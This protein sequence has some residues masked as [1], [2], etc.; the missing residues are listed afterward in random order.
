VRALA[1]YIQR[2]QELGVRGTLR[3]IGQ[4]GR[5]AG[6]RRTRALWWGLRAHH[7]LSDRA[8]L[9]HLDGHWPTVDAFLAHLAERPAT[10][11]VL[12]HD[13]PV[14]TGRALLRAFPDYSAALFAEADAI[15]RG[16][17]AVMGRRVTVGADPDWHRDP[18][19][20]ARFPIRH[21]GYLDQPLWSGALPDPHPLWSLNRH[22]SLV[23]LALAAWLS[24]EERFIA[25]LTRNLAAWIRDNPVQMGINWFSA[26]E[27]ALRLIAWCVV[28]QCVRG[29]AIFQ[30][31]VGRALVRSMLEH[32]TFVR[33]HLS[34]R[35]AV[36]G[37]HLLGEAAGLAVAGA[38]LPEFRA[39]ADWRVTGM[40]ILR[41][42]A[43]AQTHPDG[44]NRE[45]ATGYHRFV[46]DVLL[47][48]VALGRRGLLPAV[49]DLEAILERM[50]DALPHLM[51]PS[52]EA[53]MWGDC[54]YLLALPLNERRAYGDFSPLLS[55]GAA[56]FRKPALKWAARHFAIE[57]FWLLGAEGLDVWDRLV[58]EPPP[59]AARA[60]ES[61][62][63]Y[64]I[65]DTWRRHSD[66]LMMRCGPFGWGGE[67]FCA[68]AHCDLL[69][70]QVWLA[71]RPLL[72]DPGTHTYHGPWRDVFRLTAAHNTLMVDGR[73]QAT[74][75][76][77]FG[78]QHIPHARCLG[79][80]AQHVTAYARPAPG[81]THIRAVAH[82]GAG[83][84]SVVDSV[85]GAGT[86]EVSWHFHLDP[87][88]AVRR[89]DGDESLVVDGPDGPFARIQPPAGVAVEVADGWHAP[90][91]GVKVPAPV[92][93]ARWRGPLTREGLKF[94]W[95]F[96]H[97]DTAQGEQP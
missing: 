55:A 5:E 41:Q 42:Q 97:V 12:P 35:E 39:A 34:D 40:R 51:A 53:V 1:H 8:L 70:L 56:L 23:T 19:S 82:P 88:L 38:I 54:G 69:S 67:G 73:E 80:S 71:G 58:A 14:Q 79:W 16:E 90:A 3:R 86:H 68:H 45:Q 20:E 17:Y 74:P 84:W 76:H 77:V 72:I 96:N 28:L 7:P 47:L 63:V 81:V 31:A 78:W 62:G 6:A 27:V 65:R 24:G 2:S 50:L 37:N 26:L 49:P 11:F 13:S 33:H 66:Y 44:M 75:L 60:F 25:C 36:Q 43:A 64:V 59:Q 94:V 46:A 92:L 4:R 57:S 95:Q 52:G 30:A 61:A 21:I 32:A 87:A 89:T 29:S 10:T 18:G 91:Y 93:T 15:C 9:A 22:G 48:I 85:C 83:R